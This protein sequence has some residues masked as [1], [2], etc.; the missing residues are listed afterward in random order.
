MH[1]GKRLAQTGESRCTRPARRRL[2]L[3]RQ[4]TIPGGFNHESIAKK[5]E[6]YIAECIK[7]RVAQRAAAAAAG[8]D[9]KDEGADEHDEPSGEDSIVN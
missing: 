8:S 3:Y 4:A 2:T 1:S 5:V 7:K 6:G 9:G